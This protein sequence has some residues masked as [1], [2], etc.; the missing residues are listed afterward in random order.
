MKKWIIT[1]NLLFYITLVAQWKAVESA[2]PPSSGSGPPKG[3][4]STPNQSSTPKS[5]PTTQANQSQS[6]SNPTNA[7]SASPTPGTQPS[8]ATPNQPNSQPAKNAS[9]HQS[10]AS[11][12]T[13][14]NQSEIK[15]EEPTG[16]TTHDVPATKLTVTLLSPIGSPRPKKTP[17]VFAAEGPREAVPVNING[18]ATGTTDFRE[19]YL[20]N[21]KVFTPKPKFIFNQ[22]D[23]IKTGSKCC[24]GRCCASEKVI[25]EAKDQSEHFEKVLVDGLGSFSSISNFSIYFC[26]GSI[27]HFKKSGGKWNE[28]PSLVD[29]DIKITNSNITVDFSKKDNCR[30]FTTKPGYSIRKVKKKGKLI[31]GSQNEN[32][33]KVVLIGIKKE[34]KHLSVLLESGE[35]VFLFKEGKDEP[36]KDITSSRNKLTDLKMFS[37]D[38]KKQMEL[39]KGHYSVTIF[40]TYYGYLFYEGVGCVKVVH[41]DKTIWDKREEKE[42]GNLKGV[43]L[44]VT[45]NK[46]SVMNDDDR[47]WLCEEVK[48]INPVR[49]DIN[50]KASTE[51]YDYTVDH[52]RNIN[53]FTTKGNSMFNKVIIR[54]STTCCCCTCSESEDP[55]WETNDPTKYSTKVFADGIGACSSTK[56]VTIYLLNGQIEHY[57]KSGRKN[58]WK[59]ISHKLTLDIGKTSS[60][61]GYDFHHDGEKRTFTAKPGFLFSTVILKTSWRWLVCG[62][63]CCKSGCL[64]DHIFWDA[65][66]YDQCSTKVVV[67]GV[68]SNIKNINIFLNNNK[69][70]HIHKVSGYWVSSTD[71]VLD[72]ENNKNND[73]FDYRSTRGF[74]HFIPKA[75]LTIEKII[76]TYKSNC[77]DSECCGTI[78]ELE[79]WKADPGDHGL[80]AVLMG[81]KKEEK[82]LSVLLQ[83]GNYVLLKKSSKG[84]PW[85]DVTND[86]HN[87]SGVKM[88]SLEESTSK[89][90]E[91]T[92]E[93]YDPIV[94]ECRYG[95]ELKDGVKCVM[96]THMDMLLWTHTEDPEFGYPKGLYLDLRRN[97]FIVTSLKDQTKEIDMDKLTVKA[98]VAPPKPTEPTPVTLDIEKT[99]TTTEYEY[100][101]VSGVV[102]YTPKAG[103][104]FSKVSEDQYEIWVSVSDVYGT[105]VRTKVTKDINYLV[106]LLNNRTFNL[107]QEG[108]N[109]WNDITKERHDVKKLRFLGESDTEIQTSQYEVSIVDMSFC[110]TFNTGVKC[111]KV[112]LGEDVVYNYDDHTDFGDIS[113]FSL[114]LASN[115]F[116]IKNASGDVKKIEKEVEEE[117]EEPTPEAAEPTPTAPEEPTTKA[118][119]PTPEVEKEEEEAEE[120]APAP[121]PTEPEPK[122]VVKEPAKPEP[123]PITKAPDARSEPFVTPLSVTKPTHVTLDIDDTQSTSEYTYTDQ[124]GVVTYVVKTGCG[125]SKVTQG[126][127]VIWNLKDICGKLVR[128]KL[129]G[130]NERFLAV[131]L[132]DNTFNLFRQSEGK[133]WEDVTCHRC[134]V[135][136]LRFFGHND[137]ELKTVD[138][139]VSFV[140]FFYSF[141]FRPISRCLKVKYGDSEVWKYT[142][143]SNFSDITTFYYGIISDRFFLR[144]RFGQF[145]KLMYDPSTQPRRTPEQTP[146]QD[147][148]VTQGS[149]TGT[150]EPAESATETS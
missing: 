47:Y 35:V 43:F 117:A 49:L 116:F 29:L 16:T 95:Y 103:R 84:Q 36:W 61:I 26:N 119:E 111:K 42:F 17:E 88:F 71:I 67:Y 1:V 66:T 91:L 133:E 98:K 99:Q 4:G 72:I 28:S 122:D 134:D 144:N 79:I 94:F 107:F 3:G 12:T 24:G 34:P 22:I 87:F 77:C 101:D 39:N 129:F 63:S 44:D 131:I 59:M 113:V 110:H 139:A 68:E 83:S 149:G 54:G 60:T 48:K 55:I 130:N 147:P 10:S 8:Q 75:N 21:V 81:A 125:F 14:K 127:T 69:I 37:L 74:G 142:F 31:W 58:P 13:E 70:K 136:K 41:K 40:G 145:M 56:N 73:L 51:D 53:I 93:D 150:S 120:P 52:H 90:H 104:V 97:M 135:T 45:L 25:W 5:Q 100:K 15:S 86:K 148:T 92:R 106:I 11:A 57:G 146:E 105:L 114:G 23:F 108:E 20:R 65:P 115:N 118:A 82:H 143:L 9:Q 109:E 50:E 128:I 7:T 124:N 78:N 138:F 46:F 6:Q 85:E 96:I 19:D 80:R 126:S 64:E 30:T 27:K 2:Q 89:Y 132:Y 76:K 141:N 102:T 112:K 18:M 38:G 33:L 121:E 137:T 62:S 140:D 32:A 123:T